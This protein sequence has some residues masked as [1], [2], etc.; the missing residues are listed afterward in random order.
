MR[1]ATR[2]MMMGNR[3]KEESGMNGAGGMMEQPRY[4]E[5]YVGRKA[6]ERQMTEHVRH[7][8]EN[9][10]QQDG[11]D[12]YAKEHGRGR[13]MEHRQQ[14]DEEDD[15]EYGH[16]QRRM[17]KPAKTWDE[18]EEKEKA[19]KKEPKEVDEACAMKWVRAMQNSDGTPS[20]HFK[21]DL[22]EQMRM[23]HCPECKKWEWFVA[24][25]MMFADYADVARR[26][27][28]DRDEYYA[29]MAKSFL[30]DEDA[31]P[32]KLAKYMEEIPKK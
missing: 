8:G 16:K 6:R 20:P 15:E 25:N 4:N 27:G 12:P 21:P 23:A 13:G 10:L 19:G 18:D 22:A 11:R 14:Y 30:M 17:P 32:G 3:K 5:D 2:L 29:L 9:P 7:Q 28:V 31:G 26:L 24:I 1:A